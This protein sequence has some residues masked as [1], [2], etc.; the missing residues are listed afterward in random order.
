MIKFKFLKYIFIISII[1][2]C[3]F[4]NTYNNYPLKYKVSGESDNFIVS[5]LQNI[6]FPDKNSKLTIIVGEPRTDKNDVGYN[7]NGEATAFNLSMTITVKIIKDSNILFD[8]NISRNV[9]VK[10]S[11][12]ILVDKENEQR[13][14]SALNEKIFIS[15]RQILYKFNDY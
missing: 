7:L 6:S 5:K 4:R 11:N 2:G 14:I 9:I 8:K 3:D 15:L 1:S 10:K 13:A 12:K